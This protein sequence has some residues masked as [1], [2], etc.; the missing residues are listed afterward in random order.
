MGHDGQKKTSLNLDQIRSDI[1]G[2]DQQ[3]HALINRRASLAEAVAHAKFAEEDNPLFYRPE[4]EAQVLRKVMERNEGPLSDATVARLFR[5]IMSA[6]LALEAPQSIAFLGPEGTFTQAAALKHFGQDAVVRPVTTIDEI[7]RE[8][9]AG[10]AHYGV[11]PVENSSEGVVNHTLDCFKSSH[12]NVIGEVELRI[13]HQ[14]LVSEHT[15]KDSIKQIYAHQQA[16]AQCRQWLE[17]NYPGVEC[18]A[19]SSNAEAARRIRS[20]WHSAAIASDVAASTYGLEILHNNIE[21]NPE[22]TTRFLVIGREKIPQSGNDKTSLLI[23][24]HNRSG[25]LLEILEPFSKHR[26]SLTSI[27]TR[28][29]LH[30]KWTYI[31]FIDLEGHIDQ[32]NVKAA[33]DEIRP[34]AKELRILGSYPLAVI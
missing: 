21:D 2:V 24:A 16:L 23:S 13:H 8:V 25:A 30:E 29:D 17:A 7:F 20:E 27:E 28:P 19:L 12:L 15:R 33:I 32:E 18:V 3:I 22:N 4:R 9:E 14:F 11:V 34:L 10:I 6:C 5:E 26:I 31:F 1:D